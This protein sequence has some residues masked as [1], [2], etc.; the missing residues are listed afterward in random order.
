MKWYVVV[1]FHGTQL[2]M[3]EISA[4]SPAFGTSWDDWSEEKEVQRKQIHDDLL[5]E[6]LGPPP[7]EFPWGSA[8]S[9][10]DLKNGTSSIILKLR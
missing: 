3:I 5:S 9:V 7:Y 10:L 2:H 1:Y 4:G 8:V 6:E